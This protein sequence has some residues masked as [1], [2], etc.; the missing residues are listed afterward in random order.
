MTAVM[1]I[2]EKMFVMI[3]E[4]IHD[5]DDDTDAMGHPNHRS[6]SQKL[7]SVLPTELAIML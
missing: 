1:W 5:G 2:M 4:S 7:S 3:M 6:T